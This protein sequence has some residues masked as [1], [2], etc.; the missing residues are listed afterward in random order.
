MERGKETDKRPFVSAVVTAA[1]AS[2]R[3]GGTCKQ[4]ML[5]RGMPVLA[6]TLVALQ[7][8][9]DIQEIVIVA[10]GE[11]IPS[12]RRLCREHQ[13]DKVSAIVPGGATRQQ[14]AALGFAHISDEAQYVAVHDGARP[15]VRP[16]RVEEAISAAVKTG[17]A[18]LAVPVK[19][20]IK[21]ADREGQVQSTPDRRF[22][23][24]IQTPQVFY[25]PLYR[26]ALDQAEREHRD[27]TDDCQLAEGIGAAVQLVPGDYDN[28]KITTPDDLRVAEEWL[29]QREGQS[30]MKGRGHKM[31][32]GHGYDVHRLV[33][34][35]PLI[36]GGVAIPFD[37]GLLGHSDADVLAHAVSDALLD[38]PRRRPRHPGGGQFGVTAS[39]DGP[40][41]SGRLAS[42]QHRC[43]RHCPKPE[44]EAVHFRHAGPAGRRLRNRGRCSQRQGHH[45]GIPGLYRGRG[46][47]GGPCRLFDRTLLNLGPSLLELHIV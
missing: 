9:P 1:G 10:R 39:G 28:I 42:R 23:W 37:K 34:G 30:G 19:D 7:Q 18:T 14:S 13:I 2:T 3:M 27:Y 26:K 44:N 11:E 33:E 46:G 32:I 38:V 16:E 40:A 20:T 41:E 4:L 6:R 25:R 21:L 43:H 36:V 29:S 31:R 47:Y 17:A 12:F 5:L 24:S 35:R 45:G 8:V 15:L 22:L